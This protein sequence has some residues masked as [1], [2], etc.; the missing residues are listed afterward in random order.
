MSIDSDGEVRRILEII[1]ASSIVWRLWGVGIEGFV[2]FLGFCFLFKYCFVCDLIL[3]DIL[4]V[5]VL[6]IVG[7]VV[8]ILV[9]ICSG[10]D[11]RG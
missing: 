7:L 5:W 10:E 6:F 11:E 9:F 2:F 8:F 1:M 3:E 4:G